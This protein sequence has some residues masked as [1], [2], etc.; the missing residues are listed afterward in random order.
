MRGN[1]GLTETI[2]LVT[3]MERQFAGAMAELAAMRQEMQ[4]MRNGPLK[5]ALKKTCA[6]LKSRLTTLGKQLANLKN[7]L[8]KGCRRAFQAFVTEGAAALY[9]IDRF[10]HLQNSLQSVRKSCDLSIRMDERAIARIEAFS[11]EYHNAGRHLKNMGRLL[12]EKQPIE[13]ARPTGLFA[14]SVQAPYRAEL[15]CL[16]ALRNSA[17]KAISGLEKLEQARRTQEK[18][19]VIQ[20]I[21]EKR[22][23][24]SQP[25]SP[26]KVKV[27]SRQTAR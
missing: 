6:A 10:F 24:V 27:V 3:E 4:R 26:K 5:T 23:T 16:Q 21:Q 19:S 20:T 9:H 18:P 11:Q 14:K 25:A 8:A 22:D 1:G 12:M 7:A 13:Q 17:D 2:R 15:A